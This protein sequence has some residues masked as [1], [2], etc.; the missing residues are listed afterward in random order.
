MFRRIGMYALLD[1][2]TGRTARVELDQ[3]QDRLLDA[4]M[5]LR[6]PDG[7]MVMDDTGAELPWTSALRMLVE[8]E[9]VEIEVRIAELS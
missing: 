3:L 8:A 2:L 7:G 6:T 9:I 5:V 4:R 1:M